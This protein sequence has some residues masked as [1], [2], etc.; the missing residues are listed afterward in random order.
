MNPRNFTYDI[1]ESGCHILNVPMKKRNGRPK[2]S[3][4]INGKQKELS[5]L[6]YLYEQTNGITP[7][8]SIVINTCNRKDCI[9]INHA[10]T[11]SNS[12]FISQNMAKPIE[13]YIDENNCHVVISHY[14]SDTDRPII[15][16]YGK[17][18]NMARYILEQKLGRDILPGM[19]AMHLCDNGKC[20][21]P[22]H[23]IEGTNSDNVN[24]MIQKGRN[25]IGNHH[26]PQKLT[27]E[28]VKEIRKEY[29]ALITKYATIYSIS[30]RTVGNIIQRKIWKHIL[31]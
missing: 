4:T 11:I 17:Q 1:T 3:I 26:I 15:R 2:I 31:E 24:D 27:T 23:I 7:K 5:Y 19:V 20:I 12:K 25:H 8:G 28:I 6:K 13:Y 29:A 22:N 30:N 18:K 14:T 16:R 21:N 9:N 10:K